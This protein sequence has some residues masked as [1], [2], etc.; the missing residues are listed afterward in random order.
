MCD[1]IRHISSQYHQFCDE[2]SFEMCA[3]SERIAV[4]QADTHMQKHHNGRRTVFQCDEG[5]VY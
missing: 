2:C 1:G 4:L 3:P 5:T